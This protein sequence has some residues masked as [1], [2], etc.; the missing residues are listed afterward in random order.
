[1]WL[2]CAFLSQLILCSG[3][4]SAQ[5]GPPLPAGAGK[6]AVQAACSGCH[7]L[8]ML[9]ASGHS[10]N[11][12]QSVVDRMIKAGAA[13]PPD[14]VAAV[15]D[16]L[17][18]N[19][20]EQQL[21]A[22]KIVTGSVK[23]SFKEWTL[24]T[25]G[26]FPHDPLATP[27]RA[28]WYTGFFANHLGRVNTGNGEFKEYPLKTAGSAPHGLVADQ[29]GNIW[30]TANGKG[31]VGKLD[32]KTGQV[33][34]YKLPPE[35]RDPHTLVFDQKGTL[36]VTVQGANMIARI[37][38]ST[39]EIKVV[40][41]P[42]ARALPYGIVVSSQG[43]PFFVEF[44]TN[45]IASIDP[46]SMAIKE[47]PLPNPGSRPRRL[48]ITEDDIIY[49][50]DYSRGYLGRLDPK[51]GNVTEW[52]SPGGAQSQPYGIAIRKGEVWYSESGV[53]PNTLVRFD[54]RTGTFQTW[55]IPGGGGVVR[56]MMTTTDGSNLVLAESGVNK[57]ALVEIGQ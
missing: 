27:D 9:F 2:K 53:T 57:V 24:P 13:V 16:Y 15:T 6:E 34:E 7:G 22:A 35:A 8:M 44:G 36:W 11:D 41:S 19:F 50:S 10:R 1:M 28:I 3:L 14:Q 23:V 47:Y 56:N 26:A 40:S 4:L 18:K 17:A 32:P 33:T 43:V 5:E 25:A 42:T 48:A 54:P 37:I 29:D 39:G 31:Y 55:A 52:P 46:N 12:W 30:F 49:Y 20:P 45:K 38:P 51:T 21:P